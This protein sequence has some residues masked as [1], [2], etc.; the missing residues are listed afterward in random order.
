MAVPSS[1]SMRRT[2]FDTRQVCTTCVSFRSMRLHGLS[3]QQRHC[4]TKVFSLLEG[5]VKQLFVV[6]VDYYKRI[7]IAVH[8]SHS[9][10][11]RANLSNQRPMGEERF[12]PLFWSCRGRTVYVSEASKCRPQAV[13]ALR[14][15][16]SRSQLVALV[17]TAS[18]SLHPTGDLLDGGTK[19][20]QRIKSADAALTALNAPFR[21]APLAHRTP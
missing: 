17:L 5:L 2:P 15:R 10:E 3:L 8:R 16:Q 14:G 11:E 12:G 6:R 4:L 9:R 18:L 19:E 20:A 7:M 13:G 21:R 1:H